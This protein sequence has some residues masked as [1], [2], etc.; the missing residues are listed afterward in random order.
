MTFEDIEALAFEH[1]P[2]ACGLHEY[3]RK[4]WI[5]RYCINEGLQYLLE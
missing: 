3:L 4:I 2:E 5:W 1:F